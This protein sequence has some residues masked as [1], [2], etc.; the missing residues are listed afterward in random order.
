V[1]LL[2]VG[3]HVQNGQVVE[4]VLLV[5][6]PGAGLGAPVGLF[7][8]GGVASGLGGG[9]RGGNRCFSGCNGGWWCWLAAVALLLWELSLAR[10]LVLSLALCW[11]WLLGLSLFALLCLRR[12]HAIDRLSVALPVLV[13]FRLFCCRSVIALPV[14]VAFRGDGCGCR[15]RR[16]FGR[17]FCCRSVI[18]L[19]VL[20]AFRGDGCGCRDRRR[21]GQSLLRLWLRCLL[22]RCRWSDGLVLSVALM[23]LDGL[24][25]GD[26]GSSSWSI[27]GRSHVCVG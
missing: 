22:R 17:L 21:F 5:F 23:G 12:N 24:V 4:C 14:L 13:A 3:A 1:L 18:A 15:D 16:R 26:K 27:G 8:W 7:I 19:P 2:L 6:G 11:G 10:W 9:L 25:G 20:V